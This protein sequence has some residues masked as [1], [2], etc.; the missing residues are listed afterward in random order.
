MT[1]DR[2]NR[3]RRIRKHVASV[4]AVVATAWSVTAFAAAPFA[5]KQAPGFYRTMVGQFEVTALSDGTH[6][7]PI[8]KVVKGVSNATI[9][10]DLHRAFLEQPVQGSINAFLVNTGK[11]LILIDAGAGSLYGDCC[12]RLVDNLRASGYRPEQVDEVLLT[13]M[14][15]DHIGGIASKGAAVFPNAIVKANRTEADYWLD[16]A[17]KP[18]A[19]PLLAPF[20]DAAAAVVEPYR[21]TGRF[22]T[23]DGAGVIE[24]GIRAIS[25]PGHTPGQIAYLV[26]S[27]TAHLLVWGDVV[28]VAAIQLRHPQ[29]TVA[30]DSD[31]PQARE[32]RREILREVAER[33]YLVGAAHVSFPGLGHVR[34]DGDGFDWVPVNY[35][36]SPVPDAGAAPGR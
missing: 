32:S 21:A 10:G 34:A 2:G 20:F 6:A 1:T 24:P 5:G 15:E 3:S 8:D 25:L 17:N 11:K 35:D 27:G 19:S 29:A 31:P 9:D 28:H 7:F 12:G 14:H 22:Q 36:A 16:P 33:R 30:Y 4:L 23:F 18:G 13:H 26:E